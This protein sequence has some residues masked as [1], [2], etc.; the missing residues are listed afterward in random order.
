M[1]QGT[2]IK[3]AQIDGIPNLKQNESPETIAIWKREFE[4]Y[5]R[6]SEEYQDDPGYLG[7]EIEKDAIVFSQMCI[8]KLEI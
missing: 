1:K 3:K 7:Q 2:P 5:Y 8:R 4:K 6:P